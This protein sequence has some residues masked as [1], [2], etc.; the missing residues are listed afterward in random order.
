MIL[1]ETRKIR[2]RLT[3]I[4]AASASVEE[5][6]A[7]SNKKKELQELVEKLASLSEIRVVLQRGGVPMT[8]APETGNA[9]KL[10]QQVIARFVESP[11]A[12]TL[13]VGQRWKKLHS[14]IST[15]VDE[16]ENR[17]KQAWRAY[18]STQL[19]GGLSPEQLSQT[20]VQ[21]LP[22]NKKALERYKS[23][24]ASFLGYR[25]VVP[26]TP[27]DFENVQKYSRELSEIRFI[28]NEDVPVA[29]R[30]FFSA[31]ATAYGANLDLLTSEVMS[32]LRDNDML[33]HYTV[34]AR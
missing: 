32:W 18:F 3:R 34:R 29:V 33:K 25:N 5:A 31:T 7:L 23:A 20:I 2:E 10:C 4:E 12:T 27:Q 15:L 28:E 24:Y 30:E 16:E 6:F 8:K 9:K 21:T 19:F 11:K 1:D 26:T 17:Q 22:E 13:V 14:T